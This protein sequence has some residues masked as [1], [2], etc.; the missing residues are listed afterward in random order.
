MT[1]PYTPLWNLLDGNPSDDVF[2]AWEPDA[3]RS[4]RDLAAETVS[5]LQAID[6]REPS[7]W[8]LLTQNSY[9]FLKGLLAIL[10]SEGTAVI[11]PNDKEG[12]LKDCASDVGGAVTDDS[13]SSIPGVDD[14][15]HLI[16]GQNQPEPASSVEVLSELDPDRPCMELFTSGTT[17]D[18]ST[19]QKSLRHIHQDALA[20]H[21][22]YGE[23]VGDSVMFGTISHQHIYGMLFRV[24]FPACAGIPFYPES[25]PFPSDLED[26]VED[27]SGPAT[28]TTSP[29]HLKRLAR[30]GVLS[31][32]RG[33]LTNVFSGGGVISEDVT[34]EVHDQLDIYPYDVF[35]STETGG[36][37]WRPANE[38]RWRPFNRVRTKVDG[39]GRLLVNS[40]A[41]SVSDD[42]YPTGDLAETFEDSFVLKGRA[43]RVVNIAETRLSLPDLENR[44]R[45]H[46]EVEEAAASVVD[47]PS[48]RNRKDVFAAIVPEDG[49]PR[50]EEE[51]QSLRNSL[52]SRCADHL[53]SVCVPK[54]WL[55]V[56]E[57][58]R[59]Q[60]GKVQ[61]DK[62]RSKLRDTPGQ[63]K[64]IDS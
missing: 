33:K 8:L 39:E 42:W 6:S 41:V 36:V 61:V 9:L 44:L 16:T 52:R 34:E 20:E 24:V 17:G 7:R 49:S 53:D 29:S 26:R 55:F 40:P 25:V 60:L 51:T 64:S 14:A 35:G 38:T 62:L 15:H 30:S 27:V 59:D 23:Q 32:L 57:L 19:I 45:D 58:P 21:E 10:H 50:N 28:L 11:P 56:D 5:L 63:E 18:R 46:D 3:N 12:L 4:R 31:S 37:A 54:H 1:D 22:A 47:S 13:V 2:V 43:N 48:S